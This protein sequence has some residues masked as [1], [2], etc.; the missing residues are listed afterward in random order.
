MRYETIPSGEESATITTVLAG[1][2]CLA[3]CLP[4]R[5]DGVLLRALVT[6]PFLLPMLTAEMLLDS[7]EITERARRI[8]MDAAGFRANI[9]PFPHLLSRP[10]PELPRQVVPSPVKL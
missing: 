6:L 2:A 1:S 8:V 4:I 5:L 9:N 3:M 10:L 7:G